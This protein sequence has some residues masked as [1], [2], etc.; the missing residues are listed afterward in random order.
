MKSSYISAQGVLNK[1][2]HAERSSSSKYRGIQNIF[3][4]TTA[5]F[6]ESRCVR[7]VCLR[8]SLKLEYSNDLKRENNGKVFAI[9]HSKKY[10]GNWDFLF[11]NSCEF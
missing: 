8:M 6:S 1:C 5:S 11:I 3:F 7:I 2:V 4:Q 9:I 10:N